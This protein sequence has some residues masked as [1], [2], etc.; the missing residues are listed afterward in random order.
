MVV[1]EPTSLRPCTVGRGRTW[2]R[3]TLRGQTGHGSRP[4]APNAIESAM[5]LL[6]QVAAE[7]FTDAADIDHGLSFWRPLA[8]EAGVEPCVVPDRCT[9]TLDARLVPDHAPDDVWV[10]LARV[11]DRVRAAHGITID[12]DV[13]DRR[14]G[15]RTPPTAPLIRET[16]AALAAEGVPGPRP[17]DLCF[18]GTTDGTVLRRPGANHGV[19]DVVIV[20]PGDLALAHRENESVEITELEAARRVYRR[21]MM[22]DAG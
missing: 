7:D 19:R 1:C 8:I 13:I 15:W 16:L 20:G 10:R 11:A 22:R 21:L 12:V 5:E 9:L 3:V 4:S 18:T 6:G 2:A 17:H 14:E